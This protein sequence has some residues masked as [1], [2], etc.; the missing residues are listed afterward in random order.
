MF[1]LKKKLY[2]ILSGGFQGDREAIR[3]EDQEYSKKCECLLQ[4]IFF[5]DLKGSKENNS[6]DKL[7]Q[8]LE[9]FSG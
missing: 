3:W 4:E 1:I 9:H 2:E 8:K 5:F 7:C 6:V